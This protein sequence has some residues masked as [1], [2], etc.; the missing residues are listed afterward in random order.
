MPKTSLI[1]VLAVLLAA[2]A[3]GVQPVLA[4][5]PA[6][7]VADADADALTEAFVRRRLAQDDLAPYHRIEVAVRDG[8]VRLTGSARTKTTLDAALREV[9]KVSGVERVEDRVKVEPNP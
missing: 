5:S 9:E 6:E 8:V 3:A 1:R 7:E 4:R 2:A